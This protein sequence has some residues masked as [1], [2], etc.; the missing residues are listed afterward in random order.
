MLMVGHDDV[1]WTWRG[2]PLVN[3]RRVEL[4][5]L[6]GALGLGDSAHVTANNLRHAIGYR[7]EVLG[8]PH[9]EVA[10]ALQS[11]DAGSVFDASP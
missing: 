4:R 11:I 8:V 6:Y 10:Q 2:V 3:L 9:G 1:P 5:R 7:L